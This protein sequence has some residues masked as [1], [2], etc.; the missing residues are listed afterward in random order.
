MKGKICLAVLFGTFLLAGCSSEPDQL[1]LLP[2]QA[3]MMEETASAIPMDDVALANCNNMGGMPTTLHN[4]DGSAV[5]K[6]QLSN[7]KRF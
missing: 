7:G 6:C 3:M 1:R 4:L 2:N 5:S